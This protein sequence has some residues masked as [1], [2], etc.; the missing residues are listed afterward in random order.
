MKA[1]RYLGCALALTVTMQ[2]APA[3][4]QEEDVKE[5][6]ERLERVVEELRK[7]L[8]AQDTA[9]IAELRRQIEALT[10]EIEELR[11]G[12]DVVV[13][14]D[15]SVH[16][17]GP[18]ASKVYQVG[19]GA[20]L[21]GYGEVLYERFATERQDGS[22]SGQTNQLD[23]L[24]AILYVGYKFSDRLLFNSE[25]E[26]EHASTGRSGSVSLEFGYLDYRVVD[27]FGFRAGLMLVPMGFLNE[28]HEPPTF[29]GTGRPETERR[30]I[31]STWRENGIGIFG[32]TRGFS[33]RAYVINGFDAIGGGSSNA[34]GFSATG[35][36][37]G[38][39]IGSKAV[40]ENFGGALRVDYTGLL[41]FLL[42]TSAYLGKSGQDRAST[43]SPGQTID[44]W[45]V[46]WEGHAEYKVHGFDLRGLVAVAGVGDV[47][48][49]NAAKGLTGTSSAGERLVGWYVQ[50]GYDVLNRTRSQ[51]Q[52]IPYFRFER[53]NTQDKVPAGFTADPANDRQVI[54]IGAAW[55]PIAQISV[56]ADYQIHSNAGDTGVDQLNAAIGYLF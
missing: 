25:I 56:K 35:L 6:L 47:E 22:P 38:R 17:F 54:T 13:A 16:G 11:L 1:F 36:R 34:A 2:V 20:S 44:A 30:I 23:V 12:Q 14:A 45:T 53:L 9:L 40:A 42:G 7:Q 26:V 21:G 18:A 10:R 32:G 48:E 41:G 51:N 3:H 28:L 52:L 43:L 39:Q 15:T 50:A 55:K 8:A 24:R 4:G 19:Q 5:R 27:D 46:I 49:I 29:L 37:G 33:Y 31:P